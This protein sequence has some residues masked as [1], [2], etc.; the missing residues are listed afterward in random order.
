MKTKGTILIADDNEEI[1]IALKMYLEEHFS[2]VLTEKDPGKVLKH[3]QEE[4]VDVFILDMNFR[5]GAMSG[6]EGISLMKSIQYIDPSAVIIF[7]TAY[8]DVDLAVSAMREGAVNFIQ[9]PWDDHKLLATIGSAMQLSKS[10]HEVNFLRQKQHHFNE[11]S[12]KDH[13]L[14]S[15]NS[16]VMKQV[17]HLIDRVAQTDTNVLILGENGTGKELAA[18][19][20][21]M[22]SERKNEVFLGVDL[23]SLSESL[24][25][26][27]LFG[28]VRGAFTDAKEEKPGRFE[29][30]SG[31]TLF[32]DEVANIPPNLQ[33]KL[34]SVI[35]NRTVTRLGSNH[36]VPVDVRIISATNRDLDRMIV[37]HTFREDFLFRLNTI[38]IDLPSL[39]ERIEDLPLLVNYFLE[40]LSEKYNRVP[41]RVSRSGMNKLMKHPWP[42]NIR[43][44]QHTLEKAVIL[45]DDNMLMERDFLFKS[46]TH[47]EGNSG[48]RNLADKQKEFILETIR[49]NGGNIS[50]SARQLNISR[51][52][53]YNKLKKYE[54]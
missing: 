16:P 25:E 36:P 11:K 28:H 35:E 49:K 48:I 37:N 1:L 2:R 9:K 50:R 30:A 38:Q 33:S 52:T 12:Q 4:A 31:G 34:L 47:P 45:T 21:H 5:P 32:L 20:I 46:V 51:R 6:K 44:L 19:A 29:I 41:L 54:N 42:G 13:R 14:I 15:G 53:L 8:G 3:M 43:E 40:K 24:F 17:L 27:E 7:I 22:K 18:R 39:R 10:R 23:G 26:S